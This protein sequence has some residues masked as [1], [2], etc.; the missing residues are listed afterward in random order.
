M[1]VYLCS[2][3]KYNPNLF[4]SAEIQSMLCFSP[5]RTVYCGLYSKNR[6]LCK[7]QAKRRPQS[8]T[9]LPY[10]GLRATRDDLSASMGPNRVLRILSPHR[11]CWSF[12]ASSQCHAVTSV[13]PP[14]THNVFLKVH[15]HTV[16]LPILY[17]KW[18][19]LRLHD[20]Q[21]T[22]QH[23]L[24]FPSKDCWDVRPFM[25]FYQIVPLEKTN[26]A[27]MM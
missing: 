1:A 15:S 24:N 25:S 7:T 2:L 19:L 11:C 3:L 4:W 14:F 18:V 9:Y 21:K 22:Q 27:P 5:S 12:C 20:A 17:Y 23:R 13:H 16:T 8:P 10:P 26:A 6:G